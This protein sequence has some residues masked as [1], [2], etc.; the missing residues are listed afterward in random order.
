MAEG[1]GA[2]AVVGI[3]EGGIAA[4]TAKFP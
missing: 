2:A 4:L 1:A 3:Y